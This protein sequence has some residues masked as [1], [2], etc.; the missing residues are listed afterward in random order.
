M[1]VLFLV[2]RFCFGLMFVRSAIFGH[3]RS[4]R[5]M[6][7]YAAAK[8]I[9]MPG[10]AVLLSGVVILLG[11]LGIMLGAWADLAAIMLAVFLF[12]TTFLIHNFWTIPK[13]EGMAR[14]QDRIQFEK[15]LSL[16][17][18]SLIVFAVVAFG[19]ELGPSLTAPLFDL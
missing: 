6:A 7:G 9:P 3:F 4:Y 8:K 18:A 17:G 14:M 16:F 11:G 19:G 2:G 5:S 13:G 15:D 10:A 1:D 12:A